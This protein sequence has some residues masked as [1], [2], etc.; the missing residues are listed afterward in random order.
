MYTNSDSEVFRRVFCLGKIT[1]GSRKFNVVLRA[2][3]VPSIGNVNLAL[4]Y[5][6]N[7]YIAVSKAEYLINGFI[8]PGDGIK[9]ADIHRLYEFTMA[10]HSY[11]ASCYT[12]EQNAAIIKAE[13]ERQHEI[14]GNGAIMNLLYS[15]GMDTGR[16]VNE[17]YR[18]ISDE[19]IEWLFSLPGDGNTWD[20]IRASQLIID[21]DAYM[22]AIMPVG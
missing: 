10:H 7:A 22:H 20:E 16:H 2:E 13:I 4:R 19:E 21:P 11:R 9:L 8:E 14:C 6:G 5:N 12:M 1:C 18:D 17:R 3:Y 15:C